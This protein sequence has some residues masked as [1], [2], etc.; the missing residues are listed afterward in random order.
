MAAL[1]VS[2]CSGQRAIVSGSTTTVVTPDLAFVSLG[3][4]SP[5]PLSVVQTSYVNATRQTIALA[6]SG[7]TPGQ[8]ELRVDIFGI[9]NDTAGPESTLDNKPLG[10]ANLPAEAQTVLPGVPLHLSLNYVQ[11]RYGPFG[12]AA[13]QSAQGDTCLYA[14][15]RVSTPESQVSVFNRRA[16]IS[17]RLRLCEPGATEAMLVAAM[18]NLQ[19]N[20]SLSDGT[21]TSDPKPLS[22]DFGAPGVTMGPAPIL[23][24]AENPS[25][26]AASAAQLPT[27]AAPSKPAGRR[28]RRAGPRAEPAPALP[29]APTAPILN[30]P[31]VPPPPAAA[32]PAPARTKGAIPV[33]PATDTA[34]AAPTAGDAVIPL[35]PAAG[36]QP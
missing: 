33:A 1:A 26:A 3:P 6:T 30:G 25:A 5:P 32:I 18:M 7:A 19:V 21:W 31:V 10:Q 9:S 28:V 27:A 34:P 13:G 35:P 14:W 4:G 17:I 29:P 16:T 2:G 12:Y 11:N 23:S 24:A 15:Q 22:A 20:A 8:N 36:A